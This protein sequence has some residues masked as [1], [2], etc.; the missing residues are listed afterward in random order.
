MPAQA[1]WVRNSKRTDSGTRT[2][3]HFQHQWESQDGCSSTLLR[4]LGGCAAV[5][6]GK[7]VPF[8]QAIYLMG[9]CPQCDVW[10]VAPVKNK[11]LEKAE[12]FRTSL[13]R[14]R[15]SRLNHRLRFLPRP[16]PTNRHPTRRKLVRLLFV[17]ASPP[18]R[19]RPACPS[20][21]RR[22]GACG[23]PASGRSRFQYE[24]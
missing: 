17:A 2:S 19:A 23:I 7:A 9:L 15:A 24:R 21:C 18:P 5:L 13:R 1:A 10:G 4:C 12:P 6:C 8:R 22:S 16:L 20:R 14:S 11:L 3:R